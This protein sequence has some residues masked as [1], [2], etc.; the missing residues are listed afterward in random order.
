MHTEGC[1][2]DL[3]GW[4]NKGGGF[5]PAVSDGGHTARVSTND[6]TSV[7]RHTVAIMDEGGET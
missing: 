3:D 4:Q 2:T 1:S 7:T 6:D 5:Y